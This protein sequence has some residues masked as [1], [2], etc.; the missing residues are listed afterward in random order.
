MTNRHCYRIES[1][2]FAIQV[3]AAYAALARFNRRL[4]AQ[5][6]QLVG[7]SQKKKNAVIVSGSAFAFCKQS[8]LFTFPANGTCICYDSGDL[9]QK[10]IRSPRRFETDRPFQTWRIKLYLLFSCKILLYSRILSPG[11]SCAVLFLFYNSLL[12]KSNENWLDIRIN[13]MQIGC[14]FIL[15]VDITLLFFIFQSG[16]WNFYVFKLT[17]LFWRRVITDK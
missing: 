17:I 1:F 2:P 3:I 4:A 9:L 8:V 13:N 5:I 10:L 12:R 14:L 16:T 6:S 7:L 11:N 15:H